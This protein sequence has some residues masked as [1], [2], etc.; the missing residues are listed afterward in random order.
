MEY[1]L[2]IIALLGGALWF[3]KSKKDNAEAL[4]QNTET[5]EKALKVE[6]DIVKIDAILQMEDDRR[7]A[8]EKQLQEEKAKNESLQD[9]A[10]DLNK[11]NST[12]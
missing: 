10:S 4:L 1:L 6:S 3:T 7:K 11:R 5:K 8:L 2:G 12:H 9:I